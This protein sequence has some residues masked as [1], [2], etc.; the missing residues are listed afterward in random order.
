MKKIL[1]KISICILVLIVLAI[2]IGFILQNTYYKKQFSMIK[3]YGEMVQVDNK[4]MHVY[5]M[6]N[7]K[8]TIVILPGWGDPLPS[9][10]FGPLMRKLSGKYRVVTVDYFG[11]G[12]S[13]KTDK[14]RTCENYMN[15]IRTALNE[16]GIKPPYILMPHSISGIYS[17]YYIAKHP[18][19]VKGLILLDSTITELNE[20]TS[21]DEKEPYKFAQFVQNIGL[22]SLE[23]SFTSQEALEEKEG[24]EISLK[25]G[26]TKKEIDDYKKY[27][28]YCIN[29]TII[30]QAEGATD[31]IREVKDLPVPNDIPVLKIIAKQTLDGSD[32]LSRQKKH[33]NRLGKNAKYVVLDGNHYIYYNQ[34]EEISRLTDNFVDNLK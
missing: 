33:I 30:G 23:F 16:A 3:P 34:R 20:Q 8:E 25:N 28:S 18:E 27:K 4:K 29:D 12:F 9:A 14:P 2:L 1:L 32:D 6:G 17:E 13:N 5:S 7:G 24:F 21:E 11:V 26:Y 19:E 10:D 22:Q 15:E 31:C